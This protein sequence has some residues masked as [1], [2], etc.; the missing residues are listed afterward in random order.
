MSPHLAPFSPLV[1]RTNFCT[2]TSP[3][4]SLTAKTAATT[5]IQNVNAFLRLCSEQ[6]R[7][8]D[9]P[10]TKSESAGKL[11]SSGPRQLITFTPSSHLHPRYFL[12]G[13]CEPR[14]SG[15]WGTCLTDPLLRAA[16]HGLLPQIQYFPRVDYLRLPCLRSYP[17]S[18]VVYPADDRLA[19]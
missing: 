1:M 17:H 2:I 15:N 12:F 9:L 4:F 11:R 13:T 18:W 14:L 16:P 8:L 5:N 10:G 7:L 6:D 19:I 3:P